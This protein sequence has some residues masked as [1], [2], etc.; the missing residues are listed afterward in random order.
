MKIPF[1]KAVCKIPLIVNYKIKFWKRSKHIS[2]PK[3]FQNPISLFMV[4]AGFSHLTFNRIDFQARFWLGSIEQ[5]FSGPLWYCWNS[6]RSDI[7]VVS[8][9]L[10]LMGLSDI[11]YI[12]SFPGNVAQYLDGKR[13]WALNSDSAINQTFLS[14]G[15]HSLGTLVVWCMAVMEK[16]NKQ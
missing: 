8:K 6:V 12:P 5:K 4:Y 15:S 16:Q 7:T 2:N 3:Y 13:C 10:I 11:L 14:T 1:T 9:E